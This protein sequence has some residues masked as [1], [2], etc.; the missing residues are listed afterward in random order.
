MFSLSVKQVLSN[1]VLIPVVITV[2]CLAPFVGKAFHMDDPLFMWAAKHILTKPADFYGFAVNWYSTT[3]QMSNVTKNPPLACYFIALAGKFFGFG[4][5]P[6]HTTFIVAAVAAATGIYYLGRMLCSQPIPAALAAIL[7]PGFLVSSTNI[8]CDTTMLAFWVWAVYFWIKGMKEKSGLNLFFAAILVA[9]CALTKYFGMSLL[10]LL[11]VYSIVRER[12]VG[13]WILFLL[14]PVIILAGY[15]LFTYVLY[16]RGLLSDAASYATRVR[17][18]GN[19]TFFWKLLTGLSFCGGCM[20]TVLFF[21]PLLYARR[22]IIVLV[23]PAILAMFAINFVERI[24]EFEVCNSDRIKWGFAIQFGIMITAGTSVLGLAIMDFW[25]RRD[26]DSLLLLLWMFGTFIFASLINWTVNARSLLPM[27]PAAGIL[28]VRRLDQRNTDE[29]RTGM[30]RIL[31]PILPAAVIAV[32]V[33]WAD[34]TLA[35]STRIAA[36]TVHETFANRTRRIWFQGHWGFQYYMEA[37]GGT[38]LNFKNPPSHRG[39]IIIIPTNN[40]NLHPLPEGLAVQN[41]IFEIDLLRWVGTMNFPLGA[42]FYT[43]IWGPLPFATGTVEP[44][45]YL[46]FTLK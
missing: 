21:I 20:L 16:G 23:L 22:F 34:Y 38:A 14:I 8:M 43:D 18:R 12:K 29:N 28:M 2:V 32:S 24:G 4:E 11:F 7:T 37:A 13:K 42:G 30:W 44:E 27:I 19:M 17:W 31:W 46:V 10:G 26:A 33:C 9:A 15:Q 5:V 1:T 41:E 6:L 39:D 40:T 36:K 3:R 35:N 25:K 45:Q